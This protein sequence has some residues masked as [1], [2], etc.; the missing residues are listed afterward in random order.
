MKVLVIGATGGSGI[1]AVKALLSAGHEVT[2]FSRHPEKLKE[3][4]NRIAMVAGDASSLADVDR[5]VQGKDAVV[6]TLGISESALRVRLFGSRNTPINIRSAGTANAITAMHRHGL[7]KLVVQTSFGVGE[8]RAKLPLLY[9]LIFK[10]L[11]APQIADTEEQERLVRNSRLDWVIAQ[12][13]NLTDTLEDGYPL[14]SPEGEVNAMKVSRKQVG[15]FLA[16]AIDTSAYLHR[17][18]ALSGQ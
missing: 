17:S 16:N 3:L 5:A 14:A 4:G 18:V 9:R 7:R 2:A 10:L 13:V 11:L 15:S 8:S 1:A 12:P 6:V